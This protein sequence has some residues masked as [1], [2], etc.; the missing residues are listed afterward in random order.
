MSAESMPG[1]MPTHMRSH[2]SRTMPN[3]C[4]RIARQLCTDGRTYGLTTGYVRGKGSVTYRAQG[5]HAT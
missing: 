2:C 4:G 1:A 5:G 3:R